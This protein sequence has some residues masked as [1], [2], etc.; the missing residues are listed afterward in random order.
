MKEFYGQISVVVFPIESFALKNN[1]DGTYFLGGPRLLQIYFD[2]GD[3]T[4][5]FVLLQLIMTGAAVV[6]I[7]RLGRRPLLLG[8]VSGMVSPLSFNPFSFLIHADL[9]QAK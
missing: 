6:V 4:T 5:A 8:G 1:A 2:S 9:D 3:I 7:D